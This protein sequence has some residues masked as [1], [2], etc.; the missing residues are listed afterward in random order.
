MPNAGTE[1]P[2]PCDNWGEVA[3]VVAVAVAAKTELFDAGALCVWFCAAS[4]N[5]PIADCS[6]R[7]STNP[8]IVKPLDSSWRP[9]SSHPSSI[10]YR[11]GKPN[12]KGVT[13]AKGVA[14][15]PRQNVQ[16]SRQYASGHQRRYAINQ[17][18]GTINA[19]TADPSG[20]AF[21]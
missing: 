7:A 3:V 12:T 17:S 20:T 15:S 21:S 6:S 9:T 11:P 8:I 5:R 18:G 16:Y 10:R 2:A 13:V 1:S 4:R 19:Q 14:R